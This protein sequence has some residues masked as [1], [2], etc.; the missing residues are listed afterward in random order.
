MENYQMYKETYRAKQV[1]DYIID[2]LMLDRAEVQK[3]G[4]DFSE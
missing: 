1:D 3:N 4:E 2:R